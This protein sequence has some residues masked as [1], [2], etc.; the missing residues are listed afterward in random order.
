MNMSYCRFNNT[1]IDLRECLNVLNDG[2]EIE[3]NEEKRNAE[4]LITLMLTFLED[5][6][7]IIVRDEAEDEI[8]EM[9]GRCVNK[10]EE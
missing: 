2:E 5:N 6:N 9:I 7:I 3:S 1:L 8:V 4:N 10:E